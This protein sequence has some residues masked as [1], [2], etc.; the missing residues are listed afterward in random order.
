MLKYHYMKANVLLEV[1]LH[2]YRISAIYRGE[3]YDSPRY[4]QVRCEWVQESVWTW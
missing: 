3:C 4:P 1:F 2:V